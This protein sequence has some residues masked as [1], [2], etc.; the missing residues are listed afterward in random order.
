MSDVHLLTAKELKEL[1][2][3]FDED[4]TL[5]EQALDIGVYEYGGQSSTYDRL[6]D[7]VRICG[8][9]DDE[10]NRRGGVRL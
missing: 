10:L 3:A 9:L 4:A 1:R 6:V 8:D 5:C 2:D 7:D